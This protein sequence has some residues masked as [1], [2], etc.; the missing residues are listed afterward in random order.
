MACEVAVMTH[1]VDNVYHQGGWNQPLSPEIGSPV[2]THSPVNGSVC[3]PASVHSPVLSHAN[4][5]QYGGCCSPV[6]A[7]SPIMQAQSPIGA[8]QALSP[9][10]EIKQEQLDADFRFD[11]SSSLSSLLRSSAQ[12]IMGQP[13]HLMQP[14]HPSDILDGKYRSILLYVFNVYACLLYTS[15]SPRDATLSRMP[16]SA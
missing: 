9:N 13:P 1:P 14:P 7:H 10:A 15:P 4:S 12:D 16:S 8:M 3:S 5:P 2:H 6:A 11:T